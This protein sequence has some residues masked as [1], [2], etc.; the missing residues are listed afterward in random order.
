MNIINENE[1]KFDICPDSFSFHLQPPPIIS[2]TPMS[3]LSIY[4]PN[5]YWTSRIKKPIKYPTKEQKGS[6]IFKKDLIQNMFV[7]S[8]SMIKILLLRVVYGTP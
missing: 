1:E 5:F 3:K 2:E 8:V 7:I 6:K 4:L